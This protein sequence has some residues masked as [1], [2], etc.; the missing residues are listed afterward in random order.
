[1]N[2]IR[3]TQLPSGDTPSVIVRGSLFPWWLQTK[4]DSYSREENL[5]GKNDR[6]YACVISEDAKEVFLWDTSSAMQALMES[7]KPLQIR[8]SE[9]EIK[10][11]RSAYSQLLDHI[12]AF[13]EEMMKVDPACALT[14]VELQ[15][16]VITIE[17]HF[18][19]LNIASFGVSRRLSWLPKKLT[20]WLP[21]W[22][23]SRLHQLTF[24]AGKH[25]EFGAFP[26]KGSLNKG[27]LFNYARC[28]INEQS[29]MPADEM[30]NIGIVSDDF[31]INYVVLFDAP[32]VKKCRSLFALRKD[33]QMS[34]IIFFTSSEEVDQLPE[35]GNWTP[36]GKIVKAV[37]GR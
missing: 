34:E 11:F 9:L 31:C 30:R 18:K 7:G 36:L 24:V 15:N 35:D 23:S 22:I 37:T 4:I 6:V 12:A 16:G 32:T 29:G 3:F 26:F 10:D 1:M 27:D 21:K 25:K 8:V 33:K 28:K 17:L 14:T 5:E 20:S 19:T 13:N 2:T